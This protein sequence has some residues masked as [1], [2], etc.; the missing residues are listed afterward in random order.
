[1]A[2]WMPDPIY[3]EMCERFLFDPLRVEE[4]AD[5]HAFT[6]VNPGWF[7]RFDEVDSTTI[8]DIG[9]PA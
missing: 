8:R 7:Q 3:R 1:M 2:E 4:P 9:A 6:I 5:D